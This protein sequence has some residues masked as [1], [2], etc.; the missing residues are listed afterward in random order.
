MA[1]GNTNSAIAETL[2]LSD[3]A[4]EK[5]INAIFGKLDLPPEAAVHRRVAAVLTYLRAADGEH[6][7]PG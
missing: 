4:V 5:Y 2:H 6:P 3:S 1:E 7:P